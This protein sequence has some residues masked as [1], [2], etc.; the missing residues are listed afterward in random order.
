MARNP[1]IAQPIFIE[2]DGPPLGLHLN[3]GKSLLHTPV[4]YDSSSSPLPPDIPFTS[5]GFCLLGSPIGPPAFCEQVL[6]ERVSKIRKSLEV[7][8]DMGDSHMQTTLLRSCLS[9]PKF[10]YSLRTCAPSLTSAPAA[11]FDTA[12]RECLESIVG[13]PVSEWSWLKASL[14]SSRGGRQPEK[15]WAPRPRSLRRILLCL[16]GPRRAN[17][18]PTPWHST[19][20]AVS[21]VRPVCRCRPPGLATTR[22]YRRTHTPEPP[23]FR[24]R[25]GGSSSSSL[26]RPLYSWS[27]P[28]PFIR[29]PSRR[30]LA[31]RDSF[32]C[33]GAPLARPGVPLLSEVLARNPTP[34]R[35]LP[36]SGVPQYRRRIRRPSGGLRGRWRPHHVPQLHQGRDLLSGPVSGSGP[37]PG[38]SRRDPRLIV[39]TG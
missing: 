4:E 7:L 35:I 20:P 23:L 5:S 32:S 37:Y 28:R 29:P 22:G 12:V 13:G 2:K 17:S 3:R 33:P 18:R 21:C 27:H 11:A 14:P 9:L 16:P 8:S 15:C 26:L 39:Q 25:R 6:Q 24:H 38:G 1:G 34:Q 36:L 19:P 30:R 10:A 31:Q